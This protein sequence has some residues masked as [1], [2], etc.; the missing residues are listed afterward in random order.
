MVDNREAFLTATRQS[1]LVLNPVQ[2]KFDVEHLR[3]VHRRIFQD[4]PHH[5]PGQFRPE[6]RGHFKERQL[7]SQRVRVSVEYASRAEIDKELGPT[8]AALRGGKAL[9]DMD[10]LQMSQ[11]MADLYGKLDFLHPFSE[12]NSRTLRT[13][14]QQLARENGHQLDWGTTNANGRTRD[15]L[16]VARDMAVIQQRYPGITPADVY[17]TDSREKYF[18]AEQ[19]GRFQQN[20][21]LQEIIRRSLEH[22]RDQQ[23]YDR[24]MTTAEAAREIAI[25]APIALNQGIRREEATRIDA[26]RGKGPQQAHDDAKGALEWMQAKGSPEA[27]Q[28]HLDRIGSGEITIRHIPGEPAINRLAAFAAGIEREQT[29]ERGE[30][31]DPQRARERGEDRER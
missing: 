9:A 2:G 31:Q 11:A 23:P 28:R 26:L 16:Y 4:L 7:E 3:E 8:L 20:D 24:R 25:I 15:A 19:L 30:R 17:S 21:P 12:G 1:E 13:F 14:T 29:R 27:L 5:N 18:A 22:G 10:T 6:A